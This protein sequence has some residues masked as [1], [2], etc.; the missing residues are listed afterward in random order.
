MEI[1]ITTPALLFPAISLLLLAYTNRFLA[2][3]SLVRKLFD[4]YIHFKNKKNL[5][6][7][8]KSLR[9]RLNYIRFMQASGVFSFLLCVACMYCIYNS[10]TTF[11]NTLFAI[12]LIAL[13][14]S[15]VFSL[16][17]IFQS[18]NALEVLLS[19]VEDL[20]RTD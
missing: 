4:E 12:S 8:I 18:T 19:E 3:A 13:L 17:E 6:I 15:L 10:W 20:G 2:I 14:V 1:S 9:K 7:Q 5:L 16:I 11:A